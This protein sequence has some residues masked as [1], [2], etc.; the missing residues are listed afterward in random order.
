MVGWFGSPLG[1]VIGG[2]VGIVLLWIGVAEAT[3]LGLLVMMTGLIA[4]VVA[5]APPAFLA[6]MPAV[7]RERPPRVGA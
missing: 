3:A 2:I 4:T 5:A 1:R 6:P 7:R